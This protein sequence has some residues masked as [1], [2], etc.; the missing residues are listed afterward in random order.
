VAPFDGR[1]LTALDW[2]GVLA[3]VFAVLVSF[4]SW[5]HVRGTGL[6]DLARAVGFKTWYTAWGSGVS[7]W[8]PIL[9]LAGAAAL[10]L[11]SGFGVRLPGVPFLW[12]GLAVAALVIILIRWITLPT[13]DAAQLAPFNLRPENVDT[14]ASIGLYLG[15]LAA[16]IS[17]AGA[18]FRVMI[19]VRPEPTTAY[20]PPAEPS[21]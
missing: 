16:V 19:A 6:V 14:G 15:I 18:A 12:L 1:K 11:A 13:P 7:G 10:I 5:R 2:I 8:L 3:G 21:A 9:L 4:L 20:T 17:I